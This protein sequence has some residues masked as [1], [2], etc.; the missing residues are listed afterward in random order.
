MLE[1]VMT[2]HI[3]NVVS[4]AS[5]KLAAD[6]RE[7]ESPVIQSWERCIKKFNLDPSKSSKTRILTNVE[8]RSY[9]EPID[10][11]LRIA[12]VGLDRLYHQIS[13]AGY[14]VLLSDAKGVTVEAIINPLYDRELRDAGLYLGAVWSEDEEGTCGVGTCITTKQPLTIHKSEH[15]RARH[16]DLT[17]TDAPILDP[18]GNVIAVINASALY[19]PNEKNS[20]RLVYHLVNQ[21]ARIIEN[22]FFLHS[23]KCDYVL[24]FCENIELA[25]VTTDN[26]IAFDSSGQIIAANKSASF[27]LNNTLSDTLIN[28][29]I[30][31]IFDITFEQ[32]MSRLSK[33]PSQLWHMRSLGSGRQYYASLRAPEL[34]RI[35]ADK[36]TQS[37]KTITSPCTKSGFSLTLDHLAGTDPRMA[38]NVSSA[39]RVMNKN[40]SILLSGETGTGKEAFAQAIHNAS[41]RASK[42]FVALNCASIPESLIES[43]LFGYTHGAFTGARNKGMRGK[44]L[45]SDGG[46]LFLDE[47]GDM[48]VNLQTRLLRVLAEKEVVPLGGETPIR[49]DLHVICA[50]HRNIE[51]L[52][53][54][55]TFRED[56]YYRLNG[57]TLTLP[58]LR[59]RTDKGLLIEQVVAAESCNHSDSVRFE[60]E[61]FTALLNYHWPGNI[62]QLRNAIRY[63]LAMCEHEIIGTTDLPPELKLLT[64]NLPLNNIT[65]ASTDCSDIPLKGTASAT[66]RD[67]LISTLKQYKWNISVAVKVL[68]ISRSTIYRKMEKYNIVAPNLL[69]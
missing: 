26:L 43:E 48:P 3:K 24:R 56:L 15:F 60:D 4:V 40:I 18:F 5:G 29:N 16:I 62:R 54:D 14:I 66:E 49:V 46:T 61:A 58:P 6:I 42:S 23:F 51:K 69:D 11:F 65:P 32:V 33:M 34:F 22:A 47:I 2:K 36:S 7:L 20:Q 59:E 31:E 38:F 64:P 55:G 25:E 67:I 13:E 12:K 35:S 63:S 1:K 52:V 53:L 28:K 9:Q 30:G 19:S 44:I 50:T 57:I 45:Q 39:K 17:C 21:V 68:G 41:D 8:L 37:Y 10:D 27:S